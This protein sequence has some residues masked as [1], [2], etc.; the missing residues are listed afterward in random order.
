MAHHQVASLILWAKSPMQVCEY[1]LRVPSPP[2]E[3][4]N[5]GWATIYKMHAQRHYNGLLREQ[6]VIQIF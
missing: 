4:N 5:L 2:I 1:H 3:Q 6:K